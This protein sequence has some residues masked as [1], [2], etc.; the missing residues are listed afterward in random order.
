[1]AQC[2]ADD[3]ADFAIR[4]ACTTEEFDVHIASRTCAISHRP[5][6]SVQLLFDEVLEVGD[7]RCKGM[8]EPEGNQ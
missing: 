8:R 7:E 5:Q 6:A 2:A 3:D 4:V 1:M